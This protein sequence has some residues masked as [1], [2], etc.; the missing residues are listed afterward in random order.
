MIG[1]PTPPLTVPSVGTGLGHA[2]SV[3]AR[4]LSPNVPRAVSAK[5]SEPPRRNVAVCAARESGHARIGRC[6]DDPRA[7]DR[8]LRHVVAAELG[9]VD[10][11][12]V[13]AGP[14]AEHR[15]AGRIADD[16]GNLSG[17]RQQ[18]GRIERKQGALQQVLFDAADRCLPRGRHRTAGVDA[19]GV[20]LE[21]HFAHHHVGHQN[22][23]QAG[24]RDARVVGRVADLA[25]AD[26]VVAFGIG[27]ERREDPLV[28][29]AR[30]EGRLRLQAGDRDGDIRNWRAVSAGDAAAHDFRALRREPRR[31]DQQPQQCDDAERRQDPR[32]G[33]PAVGR[34]CHTGHAGVLGGQ[35]AGWEPHRGSEEVRM[36]TIRRTSRRCYA[37]ASL[38]PPLPLRCVGVGWRC[39]GAY[40]TPARGVADTVAR[41]RCPAARPGAVAMISMLPA[42]RDAW[43][44]AQ[45]SPL[46]AWRDVPLSDS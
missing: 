22:A 20:E 23:A 31:D 39:A 32:N 1:P 4:W 42:V 44:M 19:Y 7:A 33:G 30:G 29:G 35:G 8:I 45:Q 26:E 43:T 9:P 2:G 46:K 3:H 12:I 41:A 15:I 40:S 17:Q 38:P 11:A 36:P 6:L 27:K 18:V 21:G 37:A 16:S 13:G 25:G 5:I 14:R 34:L 24:A 10:G 28:G